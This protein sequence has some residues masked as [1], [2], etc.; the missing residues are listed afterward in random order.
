MSIPKV[1]EWTGSDQ[2]MLLRGWARD[3]LT[4][5]EIAAKIGIS[6]STLMRWKKYKV[7]GQYPI[8]AALKS[9]KEVIDYAV[10]SALLK[11]AMEGD[12]TAMI[13]WLKNRRPDKWRDRRDPV[14]SED[15]MREAKEVLVSIRAAAVEDEHD[16]R[17]D[18]EAS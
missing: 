8:K 16:D 5:E 6:R 13:F 14:T 15:L 18:T 7:N 9:G 17:T 3:G 12:T 4:D 11:K 2:L 10:E 1:E